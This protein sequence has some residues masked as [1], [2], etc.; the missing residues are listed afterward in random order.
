MGSAF[1]AAFS[2]VTDANS[3]I[4]LLSS[5]PTARLERLLAEHIDLCSYRMDSWI[6][7][8]Y[9]QRLEEMRSAQQ[10]PGL[11][12]GAYGWV[13]HLRPDWESRKVIT[14]ETLPETLRKNAKASVF[15]STDHGGFIH[16]PSLPQAV[17]AAVLRNAYMS[18]A[19]AA[20]PDLFNVNL[21]SAR[22][23]VA[24]TYL[25][26]IRNGQSLA[27]LLGYELERGLHERHPGL[28]LDQYRYLLRDRFPYMAGK[29]TEAQVGVN[30]EVVEANNVVNGL[31]LLEHVADQTYPYKLAGLPAQG[32]KE[33]LAIAAEIDRLRDGLD[34]VS[35]VV[36]A[37]SVHQ[38]IEGN[39]E[40]TEGA[41]QALTDPEVAPEPDVVRTPR[42]ARLL[43]FRMTLSLDATAKD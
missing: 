5:L 31:D 27:A 36:L 41:V 24:Q 17:T 6:S 8:L 2:V 39:I 35:D 12:I 26:G 3:S 25:Q 7:A 28:E 37:E 21:S 33:G 1:A 34:A 11:Y 22:V 14:S 18:H 19:T 43:T 15:E 20:S 38:A 32:T 9:S 16:A 42:S 10:Q 23:R 13:E 29:L 30:A 4:D 40:R